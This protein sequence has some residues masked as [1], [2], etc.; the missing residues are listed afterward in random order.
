MANVVKEVADCILNFDRASIDAK[1][2]AALAAAPKES[3]RCLSMK[4]G[5]FGKFVQNLAFL[6]LRPPQISSSHRFNV[7]QYADS[8]HVASFLVTLFLRQQYHFR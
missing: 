1:V 6:L 3:N 7:F 5:D 4:A 2:E 8:C